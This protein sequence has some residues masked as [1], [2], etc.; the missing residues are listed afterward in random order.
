MDKTMKK[1]IWRIVLLIS[2][3]WCGYLNYGYTLGSLTHK[4]PDSDH[5]A[6]SIFM[7]V[8]GPIAAPAVLITAQPMH[9]RTKP[10]TTEERWDA[11]HKN[12]PSLSREYFEQH[13]N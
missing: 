9:W 3:C 8:G 5:V 2:W 7:A 11:F 4:Y 10:L 12:A 13:Y 1:T 6:I